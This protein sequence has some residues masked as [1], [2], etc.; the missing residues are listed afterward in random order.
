LQKIMPDELDKPTDETDIGT[1]PVSVSPTKG[2]RAFSHVRRELSE[3]EMA[4]PGAR[5]LLLDALD[6]LEREY[7]ELRSVRDQFH[8]ADRD[9]AIL[10]EQLKVQIAA[11]VVYGTGLAIGF[12]L[13]G[14]VPEIWDRKPYGMVVL[15]LAIILILGG[16]VA[17]VIRK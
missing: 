17:K 9:A 4:S 11:D 6:G 3:E 16:I 7:A 2:R 10:R 15:F 5:R 12:G 1:H 8:R 14:I 13:I